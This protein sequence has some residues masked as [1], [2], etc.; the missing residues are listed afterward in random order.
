AGWSDRCR[1]RC[2]A[3]PRDRPPVVSVA[4][5][6]VAATARLAAGTGSLRSRQFG[7][8]CTTDIQSYRVTG[9]DAWSQ[10]TCSEVTSKPATND[11]AWRQVV[12]YATSCRRWRPHKNSLIADVRPKTLDASRQL[13]A[14]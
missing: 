8:Y 3:E 9:W 12:A 13:R 11:L 6:S 14:A 5:P 7:S 2:G 10:N 1:V 4:Q